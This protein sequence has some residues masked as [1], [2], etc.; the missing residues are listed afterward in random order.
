MKRLMVSLFAFS[1][2]AFV[3][4]QLKPVDPNEERMVQVQSV[5]TKVN[6]GR[7]GDYIIELK[8]KAGMYFISKV[9]VENLNLDS[10]AAKLNGQRV[11][12]SFIK[13]NILSRFGP[14]INKKRITKVEL[15]NQTVFSVI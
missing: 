11:S 8:D 15:G 1:F 14:M 4:F 12:V 7:M 5:V 2:I 13:P 6:K 9:D 10:L 3:Y